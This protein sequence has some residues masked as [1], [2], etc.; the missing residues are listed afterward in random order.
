MKYKKLIANI[1]AQRD[2]NNAQVAVAVIAGL[3]VGAA[4]AILFAP[5]SGTDVR[6]GISDRTKGLR[7]NFKDGY[8]SLRGK[9]FGEVEEE[10]QVENEVPHYNR[11]AP[12]KPKSDI[13]DL[14]HEAHTGEHHT[15][16]AA[17]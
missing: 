16:Q 12:K 14:I 10:E 2:N 15:E 5:E 3:A 4:L 9:L 8:A 1:F 13:K 17:V 6:E 11:P 7:E